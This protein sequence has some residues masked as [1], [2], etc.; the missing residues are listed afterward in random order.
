MERKIEL[1][2][3]NFIGHRLKNRD[4]RF[5]Q[6]TPYVFACAALLEEKQMERNIG[7]SYSKGKLSGT[8]K[9]DRSYQLDDAFGVMD[10]VKNTPRYHKKN[11]MEMLAKLENFGPFHLF[12]TLSCGDM[13]WEEN[14]TSILREKGWKIIWNYPDKREETGDKQGEDEMQEERK[15]KERKYKF[16][17]RTVQQNP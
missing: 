3:Q 10:N 1:T 9:G 16:N 8:N 15:K 4:T 5:E 11:K 17:F 13:R 2:P 6:C 14:F 12:F 7:V